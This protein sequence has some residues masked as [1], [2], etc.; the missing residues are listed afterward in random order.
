MHTTLGILEGRGQPIRLQSSTWHISAHNDLRSFIIY[1]IFHHPSTGGGRMW[2]FSAKRAVSFD[3]RYKD[4]GK[5]R[6]DGERGEAGKKEGRGRRRGG[7][8]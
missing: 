7:E 8:G 6:R 1:N 2:A 5:G 4:V 3:R